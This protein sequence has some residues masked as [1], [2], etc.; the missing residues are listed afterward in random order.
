MVEIMTLLGEAFL[1]QTDL[2]YPL[3][4]VL[5]SYDDVSAFFYPDQLAEEMALRTAQHRLPQGQDQMQ[6]LQVLVAAE[7]FV[8]VIKVKQEGLLKAL[9]VAQNSSELMET[10]VTE[11][12]VRQ[13]LTQRQQV[14]AIVQTPAVV[15]I[16][17][18]QEVEEAVSDEQQYR[19]AEARTVLPFLPFLV[20][21]VLEKVWVQVGVLIHLLKEQ[22]LEMV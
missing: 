3:F 18:L 11:T 9:V 7:M 5:F 12:C 10:L 6:Q 20:L 14:E 17:V 22:V 16:Q 21:P 2:H 15:Q 4:L 13:E 1:H 8:E 19:A